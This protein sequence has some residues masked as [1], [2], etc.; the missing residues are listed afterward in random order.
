MVENVKTKISKNFRILIDVPILDADERR[1]SRL[2]NILLL[3]IGVV[4]LLGLLAAGF[5]ELFGMF[6]PTIITPLYLAL[7][8]IIITT[9]VIYGVN[10]YISGKVAR[11]LFLLFILVIIAFVDEPAQVANGRAVLTFAVPIIM[12]SVLFS[13]Y[14]S[15][16]VA[17]LASLEIAIVA[18]SVGTV[19]DPFVMLT[20]FAVALGAWL[21]AYTMGR[22]INDLRQLNE[23]L[24][25]R[26]RDRTRE[27][28]QALDRERLLAERERTLAVRNETI[29]KSIADGV[30]VFD[31]NQE[32]IMANPAAHRLLAERSLRL[33]DLSG[34]LATIEKTAGEIIKLWMAGKKPQGLSNVRFEWHGRTISANVAPVM[35]PDLQERQVGVGNVMVLRDF[36]REAEL[37][38]AKNVFLGMVSHELRT[39]MTAIQGYVDVLLA[40]ERERLSPAGVGYLATISSS[41]KELLKLANELIDLSRM[42]TGEIELYRQWVDLSDIVDYA[43]NIVRQEFTNRNLTLGVTYKDGI[44]ELY[45]DQNR[46][47]QVLLNLLSNAYKYTAAGGT[48]IEVDQSDGWVNIAIRD[49]GIGINP[50][51][52]E[53]LFERFFRSDDRSVQKVGGTGL[54]LSI[55]KGLVELHGGRLTV[56]SEYGV[57]TTFTV[58]LP[59]QDVILDNQ[60]E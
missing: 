22:A 6:D 46:V 34:L 16:I 21:M 24:D 52:Q 12:A 28:A 4:S 43:V 18:L 48:T 59:K 35:L 56:E 31:A 11:G 3:G 32:V 15:F 14:A 54:G 13:P 30:L 58:T 27:L 57:G 47:T 9:V 40:L 26:V 50:A 60:N 7:P 55:S 23:E 42:E 29:L 38:K 5:V 33:F 20:L 53:R 1:R 37:E 2:L 44:P 8:I 17:G 41:V 45:V 25:Q 36:T 51:D 19:P 49:T 10:R 39:P